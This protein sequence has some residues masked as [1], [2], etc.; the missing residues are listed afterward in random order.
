MF[1]VFAGIFIAIAA[2]TISAQS[3][4]PNFAYPN[5]Y[6]MQEG[7]Q[8]QQQNIASMANWW[9]GKR[10]KITDTVPQTMTATKWG[11]DSLACFAISNYSKTDILIKFL[12]N[13]N[14]T[15]TVPMIVPAGY[16]TPKLPKVWKIVSSSAAAST[17]DSLV[18]WFQNIKKL[19]NEF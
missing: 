7:I 13:N 10:G 17:L 18:L 3:H 1:K 16:A 8:A 2:V 9:G 4:Y 6:L 5:G 15:D 11:G 19:P 14:R 12:G